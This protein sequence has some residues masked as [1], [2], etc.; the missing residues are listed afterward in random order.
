LPPEE[1][2]RMR[3]VVR[4]YRALPPDEKRLLREQFE[5]GKA[6]PQQP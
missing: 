3:E 2:E 6:P 1:K 4:R 5:A